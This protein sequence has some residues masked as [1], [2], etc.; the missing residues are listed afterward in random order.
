MFKK[1]MLSSIC[2]YSNFLYIYLF[3]ALHAMMQD[4]GNLN[5]LSN[6]FNLQDCVECISN[7]R[8]AKDAKG[9]VKNI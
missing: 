4:T 3:L 1:I 9:W 2:K 5:K 8:N 6:H 7:S